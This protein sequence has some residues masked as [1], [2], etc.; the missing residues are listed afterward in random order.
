MSKKKIDIVEGI[1]SKKGL[2]GE[3][4]EFIS[5]GNVIDLAVG[6]VMGSA[7]TAIVTSLVND[8]ITPLIGLIMGGIDFSDLKVIIP[9]AIEGV[10][11]AEICYGKFIQAVIN[12]LIVS[13]VIFFVIKAMNSLKCKKEEVKEEEKP[14]EPSEE[15]LLLREIRDS[16]K[17]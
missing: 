1:K 11:D 3:F 6:V 12:F 8:M 13:L 4:K 2:I 10:K 5:R 16:L 14:A 17:K 7:F 15:V 9:S